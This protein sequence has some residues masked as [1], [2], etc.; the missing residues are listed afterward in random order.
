MQLNT[1]LS[2]GYLS[3]LSIPLPQGG[4]FLGHK[5]VIESKANNFTLPL[6]NEFPDSIYKLVFQT[7]YSVPIQ[8]T[9]KETQKSTRTGEVF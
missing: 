2:T 1:L 5:V 6:S 9:V 7:M 8:L 4:T 3:D